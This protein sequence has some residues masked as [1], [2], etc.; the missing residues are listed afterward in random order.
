[1]IIT[2][3]R[4]YLSSSTRVNALRFKQYPLHGI[5]L[6]FDNVL[7][8]SLICDDYFYFLFF[9]FEVEANAIKILYFYIK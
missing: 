5:E 7:V 1:M 4:H 9:F 6:H 3:A 8:L 2:M